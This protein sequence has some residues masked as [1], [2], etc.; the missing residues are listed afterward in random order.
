MKTKIVSK[1]LLSLALVFVL[2]SAITQVHSEEEQLPVITIHS[3]GDVTREKT[4]SFVL[5][6]DPV[7]FGGMYVN[8][9]VSGTAIPG[10]DYV[11]LVSPAYV[12]PSGFGVILV[13][14]LPDPRASST[15]QS[16]SVVVTLEPGPGYAVG[17]PSSA[18]MM[19]KP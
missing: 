5:K 2:G 8:F 18:R 19:I 7:M 12:G 13:Q 6:M 10:V 1:I 9:S 3:T 11:P 15:H 17:Q 16:Y 4:G 14:T